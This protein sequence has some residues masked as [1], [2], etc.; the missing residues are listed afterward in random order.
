[1]DQNNP[2]SSAR[3]LPLHFSPAN[4]PLSPDGQIGF[5][6]VGHGAHPG[7][8]VATSGSQNSAGGGPLHGGVTDLFC[9]R[10]SGPRREREERTPLEENDRTAPILR[11]VRRAETAVLRSKNAFPRH[12]AGMGRD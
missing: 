9:I 3:V 11:L 6:L 12:V 7:A 5:T 4:K 10:R 2:Q 1:M 8:S